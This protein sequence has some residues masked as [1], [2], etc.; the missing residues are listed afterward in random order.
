PLAIAWWRN[1]LEK[2]R[3]DF[4]ITSFK[5]DAGEAVWLPPS[6]Q[7]GSSDSSL[8]PNVLSTKYVEAISA[9][10]SLIETRVGHRSQVN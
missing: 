9:F 1:R 8:L 4:G 5:F 2:L 10:G 7:I 6:V 3:T